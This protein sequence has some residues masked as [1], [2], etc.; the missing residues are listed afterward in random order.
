MKKK[1]KKDSE[2]IRGQSI[3]LTYPT[4]E[5]A[6]GEWHYWFHSHDLMSLVGRAPWPN[7]RKDQ[8]K[9]LDNVRRSKD[10]L[11]L[12][13][14][15]LKNNKTIGVISLSKINYHHRS[16]ESAIIIGND[17][18]RNG[19]FALEAV[20]MITEIGLIN[21]NLNRIYSSTLLLNEGAHNL[22][23]LLGWRKVGICKKSH[24][25][26][27]RYVDSVIYEILKEN[28]IKSNKRPKLN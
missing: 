23:K 1:L 17:N 20:S 11:L 8:I 14:K 18:Y 12:L 28:W 24:Y 5:D 26:K 16:A 22:N 15:I 19:L 10:R 25:Y 7:S 27:G 21:L 9:Y 2:Y 6:K 13:I 3:Y 4:E